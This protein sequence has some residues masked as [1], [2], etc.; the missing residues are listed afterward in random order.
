MENQKLFSILICTLVKR[1][2]MFRALSHLLEVQAKSCRLGDQVEILSAV[3]NGEMSVGKKRNHLIATANGRFISFIDDDDRIDPN[4]VK[5]ITD[6]IKTN[7]DIDCVGMTGIY[8]VDGKNPR[9]F[10]HSLQCK[11]YFEKDGVYYRCPNHLNPIRRDCIKDI[12]FPE[13][14]Y[15]EDSKWAFEI[16]DKNL[17]KK[18]VM[19]DKTPLYYY[20][21]S[22]SVTAT[23]KR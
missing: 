7:S 20:R 16:R 1:Q 11:E 19:Y 17:L 6:I 21:F 18:E 13:I 15:G 4:Y 23:Q 3:D 12:K 10:V 2:A 5:I 22:K 14:N 8:T 9:K